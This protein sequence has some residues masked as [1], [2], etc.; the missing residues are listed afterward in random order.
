MSL[1]LQT[2]D[3]VLIGIAAM[4]AGRPFRPDPSLQPLAGGGFIVEDRVLEQ[5]SRGRKSSRLRKY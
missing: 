4:G 1:A 2:T 5:V 3:F